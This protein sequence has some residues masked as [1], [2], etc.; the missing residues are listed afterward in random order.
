M[1]V[2]EK[3]LVQGGLH[4]RVPSKATKAL[5]VG[6]LLAPACPRWQLVD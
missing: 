4:Q 6:Q 3:F 1:S 2:V 5:H